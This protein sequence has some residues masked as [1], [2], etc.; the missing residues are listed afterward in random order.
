MSP[1][2]VA[3]EEVSVSVAAQKSQYIQQ[4]KINTFY[5]CFHLVCWFACL[6]LIQLSIHLMTFY[7]S[8]LLVFAA[9]LCE[10]NEQ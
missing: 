7:L 2:N 10:V 8:R 5:C 9:Y 4:F 3:G 1:G 6:F